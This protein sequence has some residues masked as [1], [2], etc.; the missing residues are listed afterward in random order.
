MEQAASVDT[1]HAATNQTPDLDTNFNEKFKCVS[2]EMHTGMG[3]G[4]LGTMHLFWSLPCLRLTGWNLVC[5]R[6]VAE[7]ASPCAGG[8]STESTTNS[9]ACSSCWAA[10]GTSR[11]SVP[12]GRWWVVGGVWGAVW[13]FKQDR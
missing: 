13:S 12:T 7:V 8:C 10:S 2:Q 9:A 1:R 3:G 6:A 5:V 11:S 4:G